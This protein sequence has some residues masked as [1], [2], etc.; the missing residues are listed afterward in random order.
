MPVLLLCQG[1]ADAKGKLRRAIEARYGVTPPAIEHLQLRFEGRARVKLGPLKT[2]V[3][4]EATAHF[5]FPT[6]LRWDFTVKPLKLPIQ[7]GFEAFDGETF[8]VQR[9]NQAPEAVAA[10][11]TEAARKRLWAIAALLLTPLSDH[12]I[13]IVTKGSHQLEA[14][15]KKLGD[16]VNIYLNNDGAMESVQVQA[17]NP[18]TK[19]EQLFTLH[20]S[21][22]HKTIGQLILPQTVTAMWDNKVYFEMSPTQANL[23]PTFSEGIFSLQKPATSNLSS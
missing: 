10:E 20:V 21:E 15:N 5:V 23:E 12:Y 9:G 13:E 18:D 7:R 3:P 8:H 16:T 11:H 2:W 14:R 6:R 22:A 1:D 4:V 17:F 19:R